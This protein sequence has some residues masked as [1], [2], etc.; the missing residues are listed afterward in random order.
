MRAHEVSEQMGG[1]ESAAESEQLEHRL[2]EEQVALVRP[3]DGALHIDEKA[4]GGLGVAAQQH[5]TPRENIMP[6]C[7]HMFTGWRLI[8]KRRKRVS[9]SERLIEQN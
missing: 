7:S 1:G 3:S 5:V 6:R 9:S 8:A 4:R 2:R